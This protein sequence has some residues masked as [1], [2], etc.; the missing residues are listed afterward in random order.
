MSI[1]DLF[2]IAGR[3]AL[4]TGAGRG[5]GK[6]L[7]IALASAYQLTYNTTRLTQ[8]TQYMANATTLAEYKLESLRNTNYA[9]ITTGEDESTLDAM[10]NAGGPFARAWT[11]A[12]DEPVAGLKT[13]VVVVSW[14]QLGQEQS[15]SLTGVIGQ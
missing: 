14:E 12:E 1:Y 6:V 13:V 2:G 9:D 4:V 10:G 8:R 5:I 3:K 15:Y 11:V 7:A